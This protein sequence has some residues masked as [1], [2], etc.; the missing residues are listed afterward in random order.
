[1]KI[2]TS[3]FGTVEISDEKIIEMPHGMIGF[4]NERLF[5]LLKHAD[6]SPFYWF[7]SVQSEELAFVVTDPLLFEPHYEIYLNEEDK[8]D[9]ELDEI[10][11]GIQVLVVVNI[12]NNGSSTKITMNLLAPIVINT[13]KKI[14]KQI[15]MYNSSYS[16]RH[17]LPLKNNIEN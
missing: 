1:L 17:L 3:R 8:K 11:E 15:I 6:G 5:T 13:E 14:A 12:S 16:H 9:L 10:K 2:S 4:S 7:Q